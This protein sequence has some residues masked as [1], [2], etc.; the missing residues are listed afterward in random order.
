MSTGGDFVQTEAYK[1]NKTVEAG[2]TDA[3]KT[4]LANVRLGAKISKLK[5]DYSQAN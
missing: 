3:N 1:T 5:L 4:Y 2:R